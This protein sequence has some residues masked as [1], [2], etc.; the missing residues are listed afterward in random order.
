M[1]NVI[2]Y[3]SLARP[4]NERYEMVAAVAHSTLIAHITTQLYR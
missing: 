3:Q 4:T 1:Y 2:C